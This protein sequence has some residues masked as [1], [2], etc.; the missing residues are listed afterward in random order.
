[1]KYRIINTIVIIAIFL[2]LTGYSGERPVFAVG[3]KGGTYEHF[4]RS[5]ND[6]PSLSYEITNTQGSA[7]IIRYVN[8]S[9][10]DFGIAQLDIL[11][12]LNE[13]DNQS[14][15]NVKLVLPLYTEEVHILANKNIKKITDLAGK[16]IS[17]GARNSGASET[18]LIILSALNL[19]EG[20]KAVKRLRFI[21]VEGSLNML[22]SGEIDAMFV[23]AGAP[24]KALMDISD[25]LAEK[26]HLLYFTKRQYRKITQNQYHYKKA[27]I[28][29]EDYKW[30]KRKTGV[31][32][33]ISAIIVNKRMP[34]KDVSNLIKAIFSNKKSL[35][36]R[37]RKWKEVKKKTIKWYV[38][39]RSSQFHKGAK[40]ALEDLGIVR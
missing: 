28:R 1:M 39:G 37:H 18:T 10:S 36:S 35:E 40:K 27:K 6:L 19:L 25:S 9:R 14:S 24:V 22:E 4:A 34:D 15:A 8:A 5:L 23:V 26:F 17:V 30:L 3:F 38:E 11:F 31:L 21:D 7:E 2:P 32:S 20:S 29:P 33:V 13:R 16:T 12:N